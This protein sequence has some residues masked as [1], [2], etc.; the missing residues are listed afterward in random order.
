MTINESRQHNLRLP[1]SRISNE[2]L[3]RIFCSL[4][5]GYIKRAERKRRH[6]GQCLHGWIGITHVCHAWREVAVRTSLLWSHIDVVPSLRRWIP[7]LLRRSNQS[8]LS[9]VVTELG[10]YHEEVEKLSGRFNE[11]VL[12]GSLDGLRHI[13]TSKPAF[14]NLETLDISLS[15][16]A[17]V[18]HDFLLH[19]KCLRR[20]AL[21]NCGIDWNSQWLQGLTHLRLVDIPP[22]F[23]PEFNDFLLL[24]SKIPSLETL[25]LS[26]FLRE[27]GE[28]QTHLTTKVHLQHLQQLSVC[29]GVP[30]MAQFLPCLVVPRSC[31]LRFSTGN[32]PIENDFRAIFS[33]I[34]N[35][36]RVPTSDADDQGPYI[37]SFHFFLDPDSD[38]KVKGFCDVL[39]HEQLQAADPI[40]EFVVRESD[41]DS[42]FDLET[43]LSLFPLDNVTF[44]DIFV[45]LGVQLYPKFW[46]IAFGSIQTLST[47]Y[48]DLETSSFWKALILASNDKSTIKSLLF[49]ALALVTVNDHCLNPSLILDKLQVRSELGGMQ[50]QDL[51]FS[52][53]GGVPP[54]SLMVQLGMLV[55][56][57]GIHD[58]NG[59]SAA[60]QPST[61]GSDE[62]SDEE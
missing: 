54:A 11:L 45:T 52:S 48:L 36:L 53:H 27:K 22:G 44:L 31:R 6:R 58:G 3:A 16:G 57:V 40:L 39:S 18:P 13:L 47:I 25:H 5:D 38:L 51:R 4:R 28:L 23:R 30:E 32:D 60:G 41:Y 10:A 59:S 61:S 7:E 17:I 35:Q 50:L 24:L 9:V 1:I 34:S 19:A 49:P 33:W 43:F 26:Q 29:C 14:Q 42:S 15:Y 56:H 62:E 21:C 46:T 2:D 12:D 37:R 8:L 55:S 20:L